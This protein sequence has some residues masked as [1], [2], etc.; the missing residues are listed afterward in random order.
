MK[1]QRIPKPRV[2]IPCI[3]ITSLDLERL[4]HMRYRS[5]PV[6]GMREVA[7]GF[8]RDAVFG[9]CGLALPVGGDGGARGGGAGLGMWAGAV[10]G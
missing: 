1:P 2:H 5:Q 9:E 7:A 3:Q 6:P 8:L 4:R 10:A